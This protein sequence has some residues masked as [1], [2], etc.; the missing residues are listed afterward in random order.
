MSQTHILRFF[1]SQITDDDLQER[2]SLIKLQDLC[3]F[4]NV[5]SAHR[6]KGTSIGD[7]EPGK[8]ELQENLF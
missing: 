1:Y 2:R 8:R 5:T 3:I 4:R 7:D 6:I